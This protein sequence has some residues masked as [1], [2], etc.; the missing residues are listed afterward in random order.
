MKRAIFLY[1][2]SL[3]KNYRKVRSQK[4][5]SHSIQGSVNSHRRNLQKKLEKSNENQRRKS[6][7]LLQVVH[8]KADLVHAHGIGSEFICVKVAPHR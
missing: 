4:K 8:P 6:L 3:K 7:E 1:R 5:R 2:I